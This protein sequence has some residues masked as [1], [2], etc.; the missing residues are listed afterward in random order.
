M[1]THCIEAARS[2]RVSIERRTP[3]RR[4]LWRRWMRAQRLRAVRRM[5]MPCRTMHRMSRDA[6]AA[7][8]R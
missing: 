6:F 4:L 3:E 2:R 5:P 1:R 8:K 7:R